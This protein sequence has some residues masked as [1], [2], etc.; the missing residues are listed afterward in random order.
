MKINECI[1]CEYH[2]VFCS[3]LAGC[4][5]DHNYKMVTGDEVCGCPLERINNIQEVENE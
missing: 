2:S 1:K 5:M 3:A 4:N